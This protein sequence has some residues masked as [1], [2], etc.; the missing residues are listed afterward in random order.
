MTFRLPK[1]VS[2]GDLTGSL[3]MKKQPSLAELD[4]K[5]EEANR[6]KTEKTL[7]LRE[8]KNLAKTDP[9]GALKRLDEKFPGSKEEV[10]NEIRRKYPPTPPPQFSPTLAPTDKNRME[11]EW[12][13]EIARNKKEATR[14]VLEAKITWL[15]KQYEP[16]LTSYQKQLGKEQKLRAIEEAF[17]QERK[18]RKIASAKLDDDDFQGGGSRKLQ[19]SKK[20]LSKKRYKKRY[21]TV[22]RRRYKTRRTK[23]HKK[24]SRKRRKSR[25]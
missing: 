22:S 19:F 2:F 11:R 17:L 18:A 8:I 16:E 12:M 3:R 10:E 23:H 7:E 25:H 5:I 1:G 24:N 6:I 15:L 20:S 21:K 9:V 4:Q 13:M 14:E